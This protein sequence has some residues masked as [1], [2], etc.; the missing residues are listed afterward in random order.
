MLLRETSRVKL[1]ETRAFC[2][3]LVVAF[4][5][6]T[7][8]PDGQ[9]S[10]GGFGEAGLGDSSA[11]ED[12]GGASSAGTAGGEATGGMGASTDGTS[13]ADSSGAGSSS[14]G[15]TPF[16]CG[17]GVVDAGEQCDD[18]NDDDSDTCSS[19][20]K[21]PT[22]VDGLTNGA[23]TDVDCGG[24]CAGCATCGHCN[25][26]TDCAAGSIC[27]QTAGCVPPPVEITVDYR[28][29]CGAGGE[30]GVVTPLADGMYRATALSS[31]GAA[32]SPPYTPPSNGWM[33][34]MLCVGQDFD[35]MRT[36]PGVYYGSQAEAFGALMAPTQD[37]SVVGGSLS[38]Y[39]ADIPCDDNLGSVSMSVERLCDPD[40]P[41]R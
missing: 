17:N 34:V 30:Y 11:P 26:D 19:M 9:L 12:S 37:F 20:C 32:W 25:T 27:G 15:G 39:W 6:A 7:S 28:Q 4:G 33:Y 1:R 31:A 38:C 3:C 8:D 16:G 21:V 13:G 36:P 2:G 14:D 29:N 24:P 35:Q 22:C 5:C 18:G 23:E 10:A 40:M 41:E